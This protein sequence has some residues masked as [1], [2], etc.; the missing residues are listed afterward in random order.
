[1]SASVVI[2]TLNE[3]DNIGDVVSALKALEEVQ[4]VI[5]VDDGS[6]DGT[7][8]EAGNAGA[9]VIHRE[10]SPDLGRSV[11]RGLSAAGNDRVVVMDGDGQHP[12]DKVPEILEKLKST[13]VVIGRRKEVKG[14]WGLFRRMMSYGTQFYLESIFEDCKK[15]D[16]CVSGFFGLRKDLLD[17]EE[18]DPRGYKVLVDVLV[19]FSPETEDVEYVF[20]QRENGDSSIC[21]ST[22]LDFLAQVVVL[23]LREIRDDGSAK[24]VRDP[25]LNFIPWI[26]YGRSGILR[27]R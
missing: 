21:G 20:D 5:V 13:E 27:R 15:T 18:L 11:K 9:K 25:V 26:V 8:E 2:P 4:E 1:M 7:R 10:F 12:V 17:V 6:D 24:A 23:N 3:E 22:V 14:E 16:D 19:T